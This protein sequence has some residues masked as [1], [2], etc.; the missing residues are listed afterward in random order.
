MKTVLEK[1]GVSNGLGDAESAGPGFDAS[2]R[3]FLKLDARGP[4]VIA[5]TSGKG[6]VGKTNVVANLAVSLSELDRKVIILDA[7]F[8]LANIDVLL[9]LAP[10]YH[11]GHVLFGSKSISEILIQGPKGV[12]VLPASSG[13][14]QMA[15]LTSAQRNR[16][17]DCFSDLEAATDYFVIDTAAGISRN[18]MHLLLMS[19]EIIVVS[20]PE[21]TSIVDA[22]A[23]IKIVLTEN[24]K[25]QVQVLINCAESANEALDV[26]LQINSVVQRFLNREIDFLGHVE[27]DPL[28]TKAVRSQMLVTQ[29]YPDAPSSRCFRDIA[30]RIRKQ[31]N[32]EGLYNGPMWERMLNDWVN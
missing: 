7:D 5:V 27:L 31:E 4:R 17:M 16:I 24:P 3:S 8:G 23:V 13:M 32:G 20:S 26:Y 11:L 12:R 21:P 1:N 29:K 15:E 30:R 28:V 18:V 2:K 19:Q 10:R 25:K 14:Q 9:G 6:G 22:Y